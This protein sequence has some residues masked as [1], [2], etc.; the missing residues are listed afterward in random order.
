MRI[1]KRVSLVLL[2]LTEAQPFASG[3]TKLIIYILIPE[4]DNSDL[5][6]FPRSNLDPDVF[7]IILCQ[8][9]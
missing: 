6:Q 8:D 4:L 3:G 2:Y 9:V 1:S 5:S 7:H